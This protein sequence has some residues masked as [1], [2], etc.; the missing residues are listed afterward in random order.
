MF[1][2]RTALRATAPR[3]TRTYAQEGV[4]GKEPV[5]LERAPSKTPFFIAAA[6]A[7]LGGGY[8]LGVGQTPPTPAVK[9]MQHAMAPKTDEAKAAAGTRADPQDEPTKAGGDRKGR[10]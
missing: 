2:A 9:N 10:E 4:A 6:L 8:F 3:F 1:A 5:N 7:V